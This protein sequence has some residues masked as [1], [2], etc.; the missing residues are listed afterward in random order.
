[1]TREQIKQSIL[2][3]QGKQLLTL[4]G[5][6]GPSGG[7]GPSVKNGSSGDAGVKATKSQHATKNTKKGASFQ[8][9]NTE[10]NRSSFNKHSKKSAFS[11][12]AAN[13]GGLPGGSTN[14]LVQNKTSS[15]NKNTRVRDSVELRVTKR[16]NFLDEFDQF[17]EQ[18]EKHQ[19]TRKKVY[20]NDNPNSQAFP[21]NITNVLSNKVSKESKE[22]KKSK[23]SQNQKNLI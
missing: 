23:K 10:D 15:S 4:R 9:F 8:L 22:S 3:N 16:S 7:E 1:M 14:G 20:V 18:F 2:V 5:S 6:G 12:G 17:E 19:N 13:S 11:G 21:R